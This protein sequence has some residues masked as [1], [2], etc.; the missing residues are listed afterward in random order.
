MYC[1]ANISLLW[2]EKF[3][4][5]FGFYKHFVPPG[6]KTRTG[7]RPL[8]YANF[9]VRTLE[10]SQSLNSKHLDTPLFGITVT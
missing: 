9:I 2:S 6:L 5:Y 1:P 10:A 4:R 8:F 3:S 7:D